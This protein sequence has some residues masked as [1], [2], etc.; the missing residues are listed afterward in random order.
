MPPDTSG[1]NDLYSNRYVPAHFLLE[2]AVCAPGIL[3]N[4]AQLM[5]IQWPLNQTFDLWIAVAW[6]VFSAATEDYIRPLAILAWGKIGNALAIS[7][8]TSRRVEA[9]IIKVPEPVFLNLI[10]SSVGFQDR[11]V[12]RLH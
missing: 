4:M 1:N 2:N 5:Q 3:F 12:L 9:L 6:G 8:E 7:P 10:K 11:L